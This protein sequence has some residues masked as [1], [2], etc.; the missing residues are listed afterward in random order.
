MAALGLAD[1]KSGFGLDLFL[2]KMGISAP[3]KALQCLTDYA[4]TQASRYRAVAELDEDIKRRVVQ[5]LATFAYQ[6]YSR[7]A[8][9]VR[10]CECCKGS[11]FI[12]ASVFS[13]K[14]PLRGG[15]LRRVDEVVRI[16]CYECKGKG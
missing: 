8:A 13:M 16:Q 3:D 2:A 14:S 11:K 7:S 1:L 6:D 5:I 9:S 15:V 10:T 12:E 4:M